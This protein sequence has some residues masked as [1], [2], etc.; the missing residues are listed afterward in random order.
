M[1]QSAFYELAWQ[2]GLSWAFYFFQEEFDEERVIPLSSMPLNGVDQ[3]YTILSRPPGSFSAGKCNCI[4][5]FTVKE[6]DPATGECE[7][8]GFEDEY[9]LMDVDISIS[10]YVKPEGVP[11][12]RAAWEGFSEETEIVDEYGLGERNSLEETVEAVISTLGMQICEGSDVIPPNARSH[13][14]LLSGTFLGDAACLARLS[15]G[16]DSS[17]NVAIKVAARGDSADVAEAIHLIIQEG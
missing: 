4:L 8:Q 6:V 7:E 15:F 5:K 17:R 2:P 12:F 10:D 3:T 9:E 11:S 1:P 13:Q 16:I 14:V